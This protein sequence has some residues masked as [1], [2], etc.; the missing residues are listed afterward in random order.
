MPVSVL[1][2]EL[3]D[4]YDHWTE[5]GWPRPLEEVSRGTETHHRRRRDRPVGPE[6]PGPGP[7]I[8]DDVAAPDPRGHSYSPTLSY[9]APDNPRRAAPEAGSTQHQDG[10]TL[11]QAINRTLAEL[12]VAR[13]R[14]T[15]LRRG[16]R[17][18]G[19]CLRGDQG[20]A[21]AVRAA[22]GCSIHCSTSRASRYTHW[23]PVSAGFVPIPEIQYLAYVHNALDQLRGEAATLSFFSAGRYRDPMVV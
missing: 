20:A 11:A 1:P 16:R 12:L 18:Q 15:G 7:H 13:S 4:H 23:A 8:R 9:P 22:L 2:E 19:R 14:C 5:R 17:P 21:E 3:L 6:P 10:E